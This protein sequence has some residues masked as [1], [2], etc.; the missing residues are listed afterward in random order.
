MIINRW[1]TR[2]YYSTY[3]QNNWDGDKVPDGTYYY[4]LTLPNSII[5]EGF[6]TI[7]RK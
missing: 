2:V 4:I 6:V 5:K 1:G 3:Y 7:V